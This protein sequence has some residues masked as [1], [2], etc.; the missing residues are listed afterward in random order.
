MKDI[1]L[2]VIT[3]TYNSVQFIESC[4]QNVILQKCNYAE[5]I[6]ID[7]AS[8][9]GTVEIIKQYAERYS[10][11]RWISEPDKGQCDAMNKGIAMAQADYIGF[12]NVDD[13]YMPFTLQRIIELIQRYSKPIMLVGN[14]KLVNASGNL[15]YINRPSKLQ[16]YHFYS[17]K[18]P[19]PINPAAYFYHKAIHAHPKVGLYNTENHYSM[20]YEFMLKACVHFQFIYF[21]EDWGYMVEHANAKTSQDSS[22]IEKRKKDLFAMY[23]NQMPF[24]TAFKAML[25]VWYKKIIA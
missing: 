14:C 1:K 21:N 10:H 11:I 2:S 23:K 22:N 8:T 12:L 19:Y 25:Y 7:A 20:D 5:H 16:A 6:I 24:K 3:P 13:G 17:G 15:I 9:D 18:E 4:I